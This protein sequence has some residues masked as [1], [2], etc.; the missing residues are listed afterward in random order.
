MSRKERHGMSHTRLYHIW[1]NM[2]ARCNRK[3]SPDYII[4]GG[5]GIKICTEWNESFLS[6]Y[7]WAI[8]SG[9]QDDLT[10]ERKNNNGNY[11]PENC[12]W[13]T[14]QEQALNRRK[15]QE[16]EQQKL[17]TS[18]RNKHKVRIKCVETEEEFE[19]IQEVAR[20]LGVSS[21]L[22]HRHLKGK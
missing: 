7:Y 14:W 15:P 1:A 10:I 9:Y 2:K 13:A 5:R 6:F 22:V 3:N 18:K 4:Y 16:V 19:C 12:K 21:T 8:N 20:Q 17:E 11:C